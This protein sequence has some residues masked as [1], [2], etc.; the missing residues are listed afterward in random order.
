MSEEVQPGREPTYQPQGLGGLL[1][2][3]L[4]ALAQFIVDLGA[5]RLEK[6]QRPP[7][8]QDPVGDQSEAQLNVL[9]KG[10]LKADEQAAIERATS[11]VDLGGD[12]DG[13]LREEFDEIRKLP[14]LLRIPAW[15][16]LFVQVMTSHLTSVFAAVNALQSRKINA[17]LKPNLLDSGTLIA[18]LMK[19]PERA[20]EVADLL[21]QHGLDN[22]QQHV[23]RDAL[24]QFPSLTELIELV[25]RG[26][27]EV[28]AAAAA[29]RRQGIEQDDAEDLLQLRHWRPSPGDLVMLA[30]REA[31]EESAIK[32]FNLDADLD[33]IDPEEFEKSG[34]SRDWL[35]KYWVAHWQNPSINQVFEMVH[36]KVKK[37]N[38]EPF[39]LQDLETYYRV[40]DINPYF[41]DL[42]RQ[43]A[44]R[45]LGRV[46]IRRMHKQGDLR[47]DQLQGA[48]EDLGYS[49]ENA[50][51]MKRFTISLT[52]GTQKDLTRA[53]W[54]RLYDI[55]QLD[56]PDYEARLV[57]I[58]YDAEEAA[59][60][61]E[62]AEVAKLEK[63]DGKQIDAVRVE[64][65]R[66]RLDRAKAAGELNALGMSAQRGDELLDEWSAEATAQ[67]RLPT[68]KDVT[69]WFAAGLI[70]PPEFRARMRDLRFTD[71]DIGLF[72]EGLR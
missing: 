51:L 12:V 70:E 56:R 1:S 37:P 64:F 2:K 68:K 33:E 8:L 4:A 39:G 34:M 40:A 15:A 20:S 28:G 6:L 46:D 22:D 71:E 14:F 62:L 55:G 18:F 21:D 24:R 72:E 31:F 10:Q 59:A 29:L 30:G 36:R 42:L 53:Q 3:W 45:P 44:Y 19:Y 43:I 47:D 5:S 69:D 57:Q 63:R 25:N 26:H 65:K 66:R 49:P 23:A 38:G 17:D 52:A 58:G 11:T 7:D 41:G 67:R 60:L 61:G 9:A 50:E 27:V 32:A 54:Q 13:Q 16:M 48:Y 35:R